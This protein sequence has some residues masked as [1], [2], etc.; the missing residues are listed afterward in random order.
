MES[1]KK[2]GYSISLIIWKRSWP[3]PVDDDIEVKSLNLD[4]PVGNMKTLFYFPIWWTFLLFW[5]L[6]MKWDIIHT[7]NF[8]TYLFSMIIAKIKRKPI[9]YD[10]FDFYGDMMNR[11]YDL[12]CKPGQICHEICKCHN[13]C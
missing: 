10:I 11:F 1:L 8:D 2:N 6:K 7:V 12:L 13:N 5:I 9:I 3:F 4:V